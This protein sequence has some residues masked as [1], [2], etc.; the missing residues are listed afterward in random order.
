[1]AVCENGCEF[2]AQVSGRKI[3]TLT[4]RV[5]HSWIYHVASS[6][7]V[8]PLRYDHWLT[9][10]SASVIQAKHDEALISDHSTRLPL[11]QNGQPMGA[12]SEAGGLILLLQNHLNT[13]LQHQQ[14]LAEALEVR[15]WHSSLPDEGHAGLCTRSMAD[16][17]DCYLSASRK[18]PDMFILM[19]VQTS[20]CYSSLCKSLPGSWLQWKQRFMCCVALTSTVR[21]KPMTHHALVGRIN[22]RCCV[23]LCNRCPMLHSSLM[24]RYTRIQ[25]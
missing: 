20:M 12:T 1:M 14:Q 11:M 15:Q 21:P 9:I 22:C 2:C 23:S 18:Y 25:R 7:P 8:R 10:P 6:L 24:V 4:A 3:K 16:G 13:V 17:L 5:G 19:P